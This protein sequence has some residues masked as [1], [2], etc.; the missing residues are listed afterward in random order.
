L[1][2]GRRLANEESPDHYRGGKRLDRK[3]AGLGRLALLAPAG[4]AGIWA[5]EDVQQS[6]GLYQRRLADMQRLRGT[7]YLEDGAIGP[8]HLVE[9]R[10]VLDIDLESWHLLVLD[11]DDCVS[12]C[13]RYRQH[14]TGICFEDLGVSQSALAECGN[15]GRKLKG[16]VES[17]IA[18]S[19]D[20]DFPFLEI[21]GWALH[22]RARGTMEALR[23]A[24]ASYSLTRLLGGGVAI[25]TATRRNGSASILRRLGGRSLQHEDEEVPAYFEPQYGC[26]MEVLRFYSWA[27]NP[28]YDVWIDELK[29]D[30]RSI[31]VLTSGVTESAYC[32]AAHPDIPTSGALLR[33][34]AAGH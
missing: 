8:E 33:E 1:I 7:V 6:S 12:G 9:D 15:W 34:A 20:L 3:I 18:L 13:M 10:H 31:P 28:R 14:H 23:M 16:A 26:E 19:R 29:K 2:S 11:D 32:C 22:E 5:F 25:S 30:L 27:P 24:L 4:S 17:E 21:G